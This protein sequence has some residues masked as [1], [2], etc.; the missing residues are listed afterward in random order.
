MKIQKI[1][2]LVLCFSICAMMMNCATFKSELKGKFD[3]TPEKNFEAGGVSV[4]FLFSHY[5]QTKGWDAIPK[6]DNQRERIDGFDDFF[7][8]ALNEFS[9]I[10]SYSTY[11]EYA[12]DVNDPNRR[13]QKDSLMKKNDFVMKIKFMREKSF[14]KN[15][16][17]TLVSGLSLTV[18]PIPYT[19]SYSMNLDLYNSNN[20]L[21][22]TYSRKATLTKWV[23]T[24]LVFIYPFHPEQ[25]KKE[26]LYVEFMHDVFKQIESEKIL[27]KNK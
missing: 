18:I 5:R 16:L 6:L 13:A 26:E 27:E 20:Q 22:K 7:Q 10:S 19:Y 11:T 23:Q 15:F 14:A 17:G 9:N 24:L 2:W 25:R 21:L 1:K 4:F 12:S 8:D 3:A